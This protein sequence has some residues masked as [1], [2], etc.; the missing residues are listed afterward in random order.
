MSDLG[1]AYT[2]MRQEKRAEQEPIRMKYAQERF[3]KEG[4]ELSPGRTTSASQLISQAGCDS[5]SGP[6]RAGSIVS[7]AKDK[8]AGLPS[9]SNW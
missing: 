6:I 3:A 1:D 9:C 5:I 8:G 7:G 4:C 2:A